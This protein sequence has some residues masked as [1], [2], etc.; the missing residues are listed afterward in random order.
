VVV[1]SEYIVFAASGLSPEWGITVARRVQQDG[2]AKWAVRHGDKCLHRSGRWD[3]EQTPGTRTKQFLE[4]HRFE[5]EIALGL[6]K[7]AAQLLVVDG[8]YFDGSRV[9]ERCSGCGEKFKGER[10]L[11][12]HQSGKF[13]ALA[14]RPQ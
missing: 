8:R 5:L 4:S 3:L 10:G 14:C 6:A 12:A 13:V 7:K 1:I 9:N 2:S 11:R